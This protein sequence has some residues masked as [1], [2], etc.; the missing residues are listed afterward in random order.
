MNFF[1]LLA[2]LNSSKS[3]KRAAALSAFLKFGILL[4]ISIG[5]AATLCSR[6][7]LH[8]CTRID[9]LVISWA[10]IINKKKKRTLKTQNSNQQK[11]IDNNFVVEYTSSIASKHNNNLSY[12]N[13][14][15]SRDSGYVNVFVYYISFSCRKDDLPVINKFYLLNLG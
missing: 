8:V 7:F 4:K 12:S 13:Y 11:K 2:F 6:N 5:G 9:R 14:L 15:C 3:A 10:V 1:N